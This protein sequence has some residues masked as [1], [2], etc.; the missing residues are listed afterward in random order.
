MRT[1]IY[2]LGKTLE[3]L[4]GF[5]R[6]ISPS[7]K[8]IIRRCTE[9]DPVARFQSAGEVLEYLKKTENSW[10]SEKRGIVRKTIIVGACFI[11]AAAVVTVFARLFSGSV[12]SIPEMTAAMI[13]DIVEDGKFTIEEEEALLNLVMP[14][15][16]ELEGDEDFEKTAFEIGS[17]YIKYYVYGAD[18]GAG[19][20]AAYKWFEMSRDYDLL[21]EAYVLSE[22]IRKDS[23]SLAEN[24]PETGIMKED[25]A[26]LSSLIYKAAHL[27][28]VKE[29]TA[30]GG[31]TAA[32]NEDGKEAEGMQTGAEYAKNSI[33]D[34][35]A[36]ENKNTDE[37]ESLDKQTEIYKI[38]AAALSTYALDFMID[39]VSY[40]EMTELCDII[41]GEKESAPVNGMIDTAKESIRLAYESMAG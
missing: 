16:K 33:S 24:E 11:A 23:D 7:F 18:D 27:E 10:M 29:K 32:G 20:K 1:D 14:H 4:A 39:G 8:E 31:Q 26:D 25:F 21:A 5:S 9:R 28:N 17:T 41:S 2:G 35:G 19:K 36:A 40:E 30:A 38:S 34:Y 6:R 12:K 37:S 13:K 3:Y 15:L 22:K